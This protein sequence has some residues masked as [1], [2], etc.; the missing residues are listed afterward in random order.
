MQD[1]A[2]DWA[3]ESARMKDVYGGAILTI[4]AVS[5]DSAEVEM[6]RERSIST[7]A[8]MIEWRPAK[9][10]SSS[11]VFLRSG[12]IFWDATMKDEPINRRGWILQESLLSPRTL[13]YASQQMA[14]ECHECKTSESG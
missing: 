10:S 1:S 6:L 5:S 13:S 11:S 9:I 2:E 3:Q 12:S 8:C 7:E 14:W 4:A